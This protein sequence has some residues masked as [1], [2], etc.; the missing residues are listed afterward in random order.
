MP[1]CPCRRKLVPP[2]VALRQQ[3]GQH[4]ADFIWFAGTRGGTPKISGSCH[5]CCS[6]LGSPEQLQATRR[7]YRL[8]HM[9]TAGL[10]EA[11]K[12]MF[13]KPRHRIEVHISLERGVASVNEV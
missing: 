4:A 9:P 2:A 6:S 1:E 3:S 12:G 7:S 11:E 5:K 8:T 13:S 10:F